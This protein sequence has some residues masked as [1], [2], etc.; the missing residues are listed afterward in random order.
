MARYTAD[1]L[2]NEFSGLA[3]MR[4]GSEYA[5]DAG[6]WTGGHCNWGGSHNLREDCG[7]LAR[8]FDKL[9]SLDSKK[10]T[11]ALTNTTSEQEFNTQKS[12]LL[13]KINEIESGLQVRTGASSAMF[14]ICIIWADDA[15]STYV[16][17]KMQ[18]CRRGID[19]LKSQL[20]GETYKWVEELKRIQFEIDQIEQRMQ[21]NKRKAMNEK[22]PTKKQALIVAIEEDG[23]LLQQKYRE[24]QAH[25]NKYKFNP[26]K[27]VSDMIEGMK[28]AIE[29]KNRG[30]SGN[31]GN[32]NESGGGG[33]RKNPNNPFDSDSDDNNKDPDKN[34]KKPPKNKRKKDDD[35]Q[36]N[37]QLII[38][39]VVA[40]VV[41][42]LLMNQSNSQP[43]PSRYDDHY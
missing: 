17:S 36:S 39:A 38:F 16:E 10:I 2:Y 29:G 27:Y 11:D 1:Y 21:E 5:N 15:M 30:G 23:K 42:F 12:I 26:S 9:E 14:G 35:N 31:S 3:S 40:L 7:T 19:I 25:S 6:Y 43:R 13:Q 37:Q 22:D 41:L 32:N 33:N 18:E 8:G 4:V 24:H 34:N 20:T 28:K